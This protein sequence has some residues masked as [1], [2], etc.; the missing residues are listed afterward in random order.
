MATSI[1][2]SNHQRVQNRAT[3]R[4]ECECLCLRFGDIRSVR[5]L[6]CYVIVYGNVFYFELTLS[7]CV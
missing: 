7:V 1:N 2:Q 5:V 6:N 4:G 3:S